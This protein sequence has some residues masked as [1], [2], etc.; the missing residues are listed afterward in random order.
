MSKFN[1]SIYVANLADYNNGKLNGKWFSLSDFS[2][3]EDLLGE[4]SAFV[5]DDEWEIHDTADLPQ[6]AYKHWDLDKMIEFAGLVSI[7][8][9]PVYAYAELDIDVDFSEFE[10]RLFGEYS[11]S[12]EFVEFYLE[13]YCDLSNVPDIVKCHLD[14]DGIFRDLECG[15]DFNFVEFN[16]SLFVFSPA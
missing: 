5:G 14:Y 3:S 9:E 1:P 6:H 4:I 12:D 11:D 13:H 2:C 8:G 15:S 10:D 7:H 16:G